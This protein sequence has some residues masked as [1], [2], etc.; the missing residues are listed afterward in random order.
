MKVTLL[1]LS[2]PIA[3]ENK[4]S[5]YRT[6]EFEYST[7][8]LRRKA[9]R[10]FACK[11]ESPDISNDGIEM[12]SL[13]ALV[14]LEVPATIEVVEAEE[15]SRH[16]LATGNGNKTIVVLEGENPSERRSWE[17]CVV[18]NPPATEEVEEGA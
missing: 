6:G 8:L 4:A 17:G 18:Y 5:S 3:I 10:L 7:G 16:H 15:G 1:S 14:G 2:D 12:D 9:W 11:D 13:A